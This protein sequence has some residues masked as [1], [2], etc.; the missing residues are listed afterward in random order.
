MSDLC[1]AVNRYSVRHKKDKTLFT[2]KSYHVNTEIV[3]RVLF[4][5]PSPGLRVASVSNVLYIL[6]K[7]LIGKVLPALCNPFLHF[8]LVSMSGSARDVASRNRF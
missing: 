5:R 4:P 8:R 6:E 3:F 1:I 2:V 7:N